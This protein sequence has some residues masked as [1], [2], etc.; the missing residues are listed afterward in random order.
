MVTLGDSVFLLFG[1]FWKS[2]K[3]TP[4]GSVVMLACV[5]G[6]MD[7]YVLNITNLLCVDAVVG[8]RI[9]F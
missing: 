5:I 2:L 9:H 3:K 6:N 4:T 7:G 8:F 1:V